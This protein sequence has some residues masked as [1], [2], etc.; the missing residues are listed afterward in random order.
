MGWR[1]RAQVGL[2]K[3]NNM[4][5]QLAERILVAVLPTAQHDEVLGDLAEGY[6]VAVVER[7]ELTAHISLWGEILISL[8]AFFLFSMRSTQLR[9]QT[10]NGN[11]IFREGK[12][13]AA[14]SALFLLPAAL[15]V[16]PGLLFSFFGKPVEASL[17][18]I[19][20]LAQLTG[21]VDNPWVVL[22]G[23]A[24]G[25]LLNL[26]AV[27]NIKLEATKDKYQGTVSLKKNAWNLALLALAAFF[28]I[29]LLLY[30]IGENIL[31]ML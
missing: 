29:A 9:S 20:G 17:N 19:P 26:L 11:M 12:T 31:P 16:I 30:L 28:G 4:L 8:P 21:W 27:A 15:I 22:G 18:T 3:A 5:P 14:L 24:I 25:L 13:T 1:A 6:A 7:G 2:V 10:V 23:L